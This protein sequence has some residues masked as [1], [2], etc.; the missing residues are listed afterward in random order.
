MKS[1]IKVIFLDVDGVLNS[2]RYMV[3]LNGEF[4]CVPKYKQIDPILAKRLN[5]ITDAT[6]AYLVLSSTWRIL[7]KRIVE[8]RELFAKAGV[9]GNFLGSTPIDNNK[10]GMQIAEWMD[11]HSSIYPIEK[12]IIL[13]DDSDMEHLISSLIQTDN[14]YGL[15]Y[16]NVNQAIKALS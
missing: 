11:K 2:R 5:K 7:F 8:I 4:N 13:D 15:T 1:P 14:R 9:T 6:G 10:R 16:S 12:F 3:R